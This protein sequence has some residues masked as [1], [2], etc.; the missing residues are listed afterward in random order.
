MILYLCGQKNCGKTYYGRILS[1]KTNIPW[2]DLDAMILKANPGFKT[3][4]DLFKTKGE[5]F[6]RCCEVNTLEK[7]LK[8]NKEKT[9]IISLGGGS[10]ESP[11]LVQTANNTGLTV[12]LH[13]EKSVIWERTVKDGIP[14]YLGKNPKEDF[15]VI[16]SKRDELYSSLCRIMINLSGKS[17][18]Q[19][20]Q[21][22]SEQF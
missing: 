22:L 7:F 6:F 16:Y 19:I 13:E 8:D 11:A 20:C 18:E 15:N 4:R 21:I 1:E 14:P 10:F 2:Y 3:C 9:C 5:S 17:T 12:Y